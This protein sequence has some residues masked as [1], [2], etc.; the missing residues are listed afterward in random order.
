MI[1]IERS[2][3]SKILLHFWMGLTHYLPG[4][5]DTVLRSADM[6]NL[7]GVMATRVRDEAGLVGVQ[8]CI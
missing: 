6:D 4:L 7:G 5:Q 8:I 3:G 2:R 1:A